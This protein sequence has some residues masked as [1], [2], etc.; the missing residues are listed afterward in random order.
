[1]SIGLSNFGLCGN[2]YAYKSSGFCYHSLNFSMIIIGIEVPE[3][4]RIQSRL[5]FTYFCF[6]WNFTRLTMTYV[7]GLSFDQSGTIR[8]RAK[9]STARFGNSRLKM[10]RK[11]KFPSFQCPNGVTPLASQNNLSQSQSSDCSRTGLGCI[12]ANVIVSDRLRNM[13]NKGL[14]SWPSS[15]VSLWQVICRAWGD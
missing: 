9:H 8:P 15:K 14:N 13:G 7:Q 1:M 4:L 5:G 3:V 6:H 10:I 2:H 12:A 11:S